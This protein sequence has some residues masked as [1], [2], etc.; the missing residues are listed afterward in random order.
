MMGARSRGRETTRVPAPLN[1]TQSAATVGRM[2]TG[3]QMII[4]VKMSSCH[5]SSDGA[6]Q[7]RSASVTPPARPLSVLGSSSGSLQRTPSY[8]LLGG[9]L[10]DSMTAGAGSSWRDSDTAVTG[11]AADQATSMN[12]LRQKIHFFSGYYS[13]YSSGSRT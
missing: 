1:R 2:N 8:R 4:S 12:I 5:Y 11:A 10:M 3:T 9:K 13:F 6:G 7:I